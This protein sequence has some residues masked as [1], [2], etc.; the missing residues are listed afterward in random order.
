MG[1]DVTI[2]G[3]VL[4]AARHLDM[5]GGAAAGSPR[6]HFHREQQNQ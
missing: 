4:A 6:T 5:D 2:S 3:Q 1:S